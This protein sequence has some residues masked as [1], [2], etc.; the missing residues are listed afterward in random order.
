LFEQIVGRGPEQVKA[1]LGHYRHWP[2]TR[3]YPEAQVVA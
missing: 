1:L 2:S 3:R